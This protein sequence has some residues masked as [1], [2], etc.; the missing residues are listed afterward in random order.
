MHVGAYFSAWLREVFVGLLEPRRPSG[1]LQPVTQ[2]LP[3]ARHL[4]SWNYFCQV[5]FMGG[6]SFFDDIRRDVTSPTTISCTASWNQF[7]GTKVADL[8]L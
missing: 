3:K 7:L 6:L 5:V 8:L 4:F 2:R 1:K